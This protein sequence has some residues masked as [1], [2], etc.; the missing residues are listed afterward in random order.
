MLEILERLGLL[1]KDKEPV[2]IEGKQCM[3][4]IWV[5]NKLPDF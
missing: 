3:K 4:F 1:K 2:F 5:K